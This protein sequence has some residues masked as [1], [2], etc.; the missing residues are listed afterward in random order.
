MNDYTMV[1]RVVDPTLRAYAFIYSPQY[2]SDDN[3]LLFPHNPSDVRELRF[4]WMYVG[5]S[6][7]ALPAE[8]PLTFH[9]NAEED[10]VSVLGN[11]VSSVYQ[12]NIY[13][14]F[15]VHAKSVFSRMYR[16]YWLRKHQNSMVASHLSD[17]AKITIDLCEAFHYPAVLS[18]VERTSFCA[19]DI[20]EWLKISTSDV[21][22]EH[23][24]LHGLAARLQ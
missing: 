10:I 18:Y 14:F 5:P 24:L 15:T 11:L 21:P 6:G 3:K 12:Q 1:R 13:G 16:W 7:I 22:A 17:V 8:V 2:V 9:T 4:S 20:Q 23:A 19:D